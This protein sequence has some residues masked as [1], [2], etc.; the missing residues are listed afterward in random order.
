M[1]PHG[2]GRFPAREG[3][4]GVHADGRADHEGGDARDRRGPTSTGGSAAPGPLPAVF[5]P[6][7]SK[8]P[9]PKPKPR[10]PLTPPPRGTRRGPFFRP[11]PRGARR[12][13][14]PTGGGPPQP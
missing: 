14:P 5:P 9:F 12:G 13:A 10:R 7:S 4:L 8:P 6:R 11:R 3:V 1:G 2:D